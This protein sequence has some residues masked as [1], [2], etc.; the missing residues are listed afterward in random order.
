MSGSMWICHPTVNK[1]QPLP[2]EAHSQIITTQDVE[3]CIRT[4]QGML[5]RHRR[6]ASN[7]GAASPKEF[8]LLLEAPSMLRIP[9]MLVGEEDFAPHRLRRAPSNAFPSNFPHCCV[10]PLLGSPQSLAL[11]QQGHLDS[12]TIAH[13]W[14]PH[15][16]P[17]KTTLAAPFWLVLPSLLLPQLL[18]ALPSGLWDLCVALLL[19]VKDMAHGQTATTSLSWA[20]AFPLLVNAVFPSAAT[21]CGNC[22]DRHEAV[23]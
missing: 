5:Q 21:H 4:G 6:R 7:P 20:Q 23:S 1:I 11:H 13:R 10:A 2:Q 3:C 17:D 19:P 22:Q 12:W 16:T 18:L 9:W 8:C 14:I 15:P